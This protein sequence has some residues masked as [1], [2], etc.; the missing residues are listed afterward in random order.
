MSNMQNAR[1]EH[2]IV[3]YDVVDSDIRVAKIL[4]V[5]VTLCL[6]VIRSAWAKVW[7]I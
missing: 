3:V 7:L 1:K 6:A 2:S 5:Q 4:N